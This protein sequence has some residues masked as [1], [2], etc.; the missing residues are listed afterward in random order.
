VPRGCER[1]PDCL[2]ALKRAY[3]LKFR[4]VRRVQPGLV[5][6]ALRNGRAQVSLVSTTDPHIHRSG[7]TLL[8]DDR[9][10]FAAAGP[11]VLGRKLLARRGGRALRA[12]LDKADSGLTLDVMEELNARVDF[13]EEP[14]ARV[15]HDYLHATG[16]L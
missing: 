13:D 10:A 9:R 7:E 1:Q 8:F 11:V 3:D 15:A 12:A 14:V 6:E 16:L 2:P 4:S 5:H